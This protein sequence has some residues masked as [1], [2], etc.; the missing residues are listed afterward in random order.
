M[1]IFNYKFKIEDYRVK[2]SHKFDEENLSDY[3]SDKLADFSSIRAVGQFNV[4]QSNPTFIIESTEGKRYVLRKKPPGDLLPSA[5]A[6]DREFKVQNALYETDVPVAKMYLYCEDESIIG[7]AFYIME[8]IEG[9]VLEDTKLAG[10]GVDERKAIYDSMNSALA[11]LHNVNIKNVGLEDFGRPGSYF[12]RQIKRWSNQ[13]EL[14]KQHDMPEMPLL[15]EWLISNIPEDDQTTIVHGD[16]RL[17]NLIYDL[18]EPKVI[19]VLDWELSTLG[20]PLADLGYNLMHHVQPTNLFSG[21]KGLNLKDLGIPDIDTYMK[22]YCDRVHRDFIDPTFY[23][24]FSLYRN[25]AILEGVLAR[26]RAGNASSSL[27]EERG[28]LGPVLAK[29]S[30]NLVKENNLD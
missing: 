9:R 6:V 2:E 1:T 10:F 21:L 5:H 27:A 19:A 16:Y 15:K 22:N 4:G 28:A 30:W 7:T 17:G 8:Y 13:W 24:V 14:S 18:N 3:L 20:H 12:T 23:I 29:L 11:A 25:V 26:G